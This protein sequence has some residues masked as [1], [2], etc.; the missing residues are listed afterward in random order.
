MLAQGATVEEIV[1]GY[2]ALDAEKIAIAPLYIRAFPRRGR[3]T[4]RSWQGKPRG[5]RSF[6]LSSLLKTA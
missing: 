5:K 2:P 1:D 6:P 3:P 4:R